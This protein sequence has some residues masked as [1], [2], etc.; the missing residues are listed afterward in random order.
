M[1]PIYKAQ[2]EPTWSNGWLEKFQ[3]AHDEINSIREAL[4]DVPLSDTYNCD[5]TGLFYKAVPDVFLST[6]QLPCYKANKDRIPAMHTVSASGQSL[7]IWCIGMS[8]QPHCFRNIKVDTFNFFYRSNK[9]AWMNTEI[10]IEYP[11]WFDG[12]MSGRKV[13][14][15]M[16]NFSAHKAAFEYLNTGSFY[17][18]EKY[19][20]YFFSSK[21]NISASAP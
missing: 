9:K 8:R 18:S 21:C 10:I 2:R 17:N 12:Q 5:E 14:L 16:D 3:K 11:K 19:Q 15:I 1:M 20:G 6:C 4:V 7:K 13:I